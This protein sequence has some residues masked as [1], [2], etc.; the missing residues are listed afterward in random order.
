M[1]HRDNRVSGMAVGGAV[2]IVVGLLALLMQQLSIDVATWLGGSGWTLFIIVPGLILLALAAVLRG[3]QAQ[4]ATIA[5]AVVTTVGLLLLYQDQNAHYES[6]A[7][8]WTLIPASVGLALAVNGLRFARRDLV[9]IGTRMI[10]GF[11]VLFLA[12]AWYFETIFQT[13]RVPFDLGESWPIALIVLGGL[14]LAIG[15][16]RGSRS[17]VSDDSA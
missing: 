6:W 3:G 7:Y 14:V 10:A 13:D 16:L 8:A 17:E 5:G 1:T 2:V 15:L 11:G 9:S 4:G 12:G